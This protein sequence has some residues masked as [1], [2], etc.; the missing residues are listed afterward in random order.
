[1]V[2]KSV[3]L[4]PFGF[5]VSFCPFLVALVFDRFDRF[6]FARFGARSPLGPLGWQWLEEAI[7][8]PRAGLLDKPRLQWQGYKS[9]DGTLPLTSTAVTA[10]PGHLQ[11]FFWK[12]RK[13]LGPC[14]AHFV[15]V[16]CG[17][18]SWGVW[19]WGRVGDG[20]RGERERCGAVRC[21]AVRCGA[22]RCGAVRWGGVG[23]GGVGWSGVDVEWS[24][25]VVGG[26]EGR[27]DECVCGEKERTRSW[28]SD[29]E[30]PM[31]VV[32]TGALLVN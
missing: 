24:G 11:P 25:C 1:M 2:G 10:K 14:R 26:R 31:P 6:W 13:K 29:G 5:F 21:G 8:L 12:G 16:W 30:A 27:R 4:I 19:V 23:W 20:R 28:A 3:S 17:G 18:G 7:F 15:V 22:V 9:Q 32:S